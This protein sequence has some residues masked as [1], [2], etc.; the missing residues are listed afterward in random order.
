[1]LLR[2]I[3]LLCISQLDFWCRP[4]FIADQTGSRQLQMHMDHLLVESEILFL[5]P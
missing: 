1:M 4:V 3:G 5:V 2:V